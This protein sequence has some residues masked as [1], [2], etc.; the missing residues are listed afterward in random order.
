M[1]FWTQ[2]QHFILFPL[3]GFPLITFVSSLLIAIGFHIWQRQK[4]QRSFNLRVILRGLFPAALLHSASSQVDIGFVLLAALV[5]PPVIAHLTIT[6]HF[7][8]H[9]IGQGLTHVLGPCAPST[10]PDGVLIFILSIVMYIAYEIAYWVDHI[11]SHRVPFLWEFHKIHHTA[12][13]LSPMTNFR[14]HIVDTIVFSN[15]IVLFGSFFQAVYI[16]MIGRQID[17]VMIGGLNIFLFIG[18]L[19]LGHLQHTSV[20]IPF[21]GIWGK[22]FISPAHHQL[23]HSDDPRHYD[24]NYGSFLAIWDWM[25]GTLIIPQAAREAIHY[26]VVGDDTAG[27]LVQSQIKPFTRACALLMRS[28]K[29]LVPFQ[30]KPQGEVAP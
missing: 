9:A 5:F 17:E 14:V 28:V 15:I 6:G 19:F 12:H 11:L 18:V 23:H 8:Y 7:L 16:W 21:R 3:Y 30:T 2:F 4:R 22:L 10:L 20:W 26:G 27:S 29:S 24:C 13:L 1:S 25:A